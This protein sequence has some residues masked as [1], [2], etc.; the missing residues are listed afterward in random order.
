MLPAPAN[1]RFATASPVFNELSL[2][3]ASAATTETG[4]EIWR[5]PTDQANWTRLA[6]L[7]AKTTTHT[8]RNLRTG[9]LY[10]YRVRTMQGSTASEWSNVVSDR[11]PLVNAT[12]LPAEVRVFPNPTTDRLT[13]KGLGLE[14][15]VQVQVCALNGQ[16]LI[17]QTAESTG[18]AVQIHLADLPAGLY[19]L[20]LSAETVRFSTLIL[21]H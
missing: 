19:V 16:E 8:D 21:K 13:I 2:L 12:A 7:P 10:H 14:G 1:L 6:E 5:S 11:P 20:R 17:T 4:C 3:W 18:G 15:V 9:T